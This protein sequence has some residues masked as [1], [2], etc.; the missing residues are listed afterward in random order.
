MCGADAL[1]TFRRDEFCLDAGK[2]YGFDIN[3]TLH[4]QVEAIQMETK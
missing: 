1:A 4:I 3:V 2:D